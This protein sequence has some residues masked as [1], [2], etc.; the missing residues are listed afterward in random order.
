MPLKVY[1]EKRDFRKTPEPQPSTVPK[2][3][4]GLVYVIQKH[5]ASHL[6]Y[7]L[8]LEEGGVL[9]SWAIPKLPPQEEGVRRLAVE[10]EDHP[11]GYEKFEGVIPEGE[12]GAGK[13]EVWDQGTYLPQETDPGKRIVE[14]KGY[15][16]SGRY[17]LI[18]LK[19]KNPED[20]NWLFF[21]LKS[22]L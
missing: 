12:Y 19:V 1:K 22:P 21:K 10:T 4:E 16:L 2:K 20:K 9:K 17:G 11:L 8:R 6:H 18:K 7:D 13:V 14:I 5:Q 15:K 3:R